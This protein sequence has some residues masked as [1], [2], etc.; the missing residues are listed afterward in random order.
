MSSHRDINYYIDLLNKA[1]LSIKKIYDLSHEQATIVKEY[2]DD[3][4]RKEFIR[5]N[6]L[7][8]VMSILI[9][10]K[11]ND[12]LRVCVDYRA[13]NAFTIK[14]RNILPLIK[15]TLIHL[16]RAKIYSKFDVIVIFNEIR[17]K[18]R[19]K[20]RSLFL[21]ATTYLNIL[22]CRLI[23]AILL[24]SFNCLSTRFYENI[25]TTFAQLIS[26]TF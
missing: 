6:I 26:T 24:V 23:F 10:K 20:K 11:L 22:L 15:K 3:I 25:S 8:Y 19:N 12:D 13:L 1:L 5:F 14:N 16:C 9:V 4:L 21:R 7:L 18:K 2:I 17:V